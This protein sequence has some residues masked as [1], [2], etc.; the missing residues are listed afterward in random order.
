MYRTLLLFGDPVIPFTIDRFTLI[1][2]ADLKYFDQF[3]NLFEDS[4]ISFL[5]MNYRSQKAIVNHANSFMHSATAMRYLSHNDGG[6]VEEIDADKNRVAVMAECLKIINAHQGKDIAILTRT[7]RIL[8][9]DIHDCLDVIKEK[10]VQTCSKINVRISTVHSFK[11]SECDLAILL[12][13]KWHFPLLHRDR[14]FFELF[15]S[16][17][18]IMREEH[19]LWFVGITRSKGK[20]FIL[21]I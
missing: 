14:A 1:I 12:K 8:G 17:A 13:I 19:R 9:M 3:Q 6:S 2:C 20:L 7:N 11:G 15:D 16:E 18:D 10:I 4:S 5:T 21:K